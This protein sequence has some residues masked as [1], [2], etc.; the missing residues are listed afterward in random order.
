MPLS[1]IAIPFPSRIRSGDTS[2]LRQS[3]RRRA[4]SRSAGSGNVPDFFASAYACQSGWTVTSKAPPV[5]PET[6]RAF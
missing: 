6:V 3:T 5:L 4:R 1:V 2:T